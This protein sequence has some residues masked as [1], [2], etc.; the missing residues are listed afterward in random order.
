MAGQRQIWPGMFSYQEISKNG[1]D[2][3]QKLELSVHK[4][5]ETIHIRLFGGGLFVMSDIFHKLVWN[6][7]NTKNIINMIK[8]LT[9]AFA[10]MLLCLYASAQG[11]GGPHYPSPIV[12]PDNTVTFNLNAPQAK[13]VRIS[14]QFAPKADMQRLDNGVWTITLGPVTPD[15]Y[16]YCFEVD[17]IAVMDPQ[18]PEWFPNEKFKN[19]L[20]DVRGDKPLAHELRSVPH[21]KVDY[22]N[23][24]SETMGVYGNAIVYTPPTYDKNPD[25]KYPVFYLISGTTDTEEVYFKVGRMN[26]ILDNL[27]AEGKAKEMI[28]VLPYGN[29][30]KYF[31]AGTFD[32]TKGDVFSKDLLNDLMPYVEANYRTLNDRDSRA[33]GGFSR[34]G[35]QGLAFGLSNLD[36][37][38]YLCSYSSFTSKDIPGVYDKA[39]K[40]NKKINLFWLGVGTDDFLYGNAKEYAEFLDSKGI[41]NIQ[42]YTTGMFGHTWMNARY[43]LSE[44]FPLL[45]NKEASKAAMDQASKDKPKKVKKVEDKPEAPAAKPDQQRLTPEVMAR[46]F[47]P[48]VVS[49]DYNKDG[50]VTFRVLAP[51]AEKVEL[52]CQMFEGTRLMTKDDRGVWEVT[53]TPEVP[54][55]YP[56]SFIIDGTK[57]ADPENMNIFPNE[58]YKA[59][60]ADIKAAQPDPQDLQ[61]VPHGKVTYTYYTSNAVGFDRPVCIYTPA[62]YD[63]AGTEKY[64]VLYLIHG[65]TDTY[66]T[67]FKVGKVNNILDNLIAAGLAKKM[68]VVMPYANPYP[69]MMLRGMAKA[70]NALDTQLTT[71]EFTES[72][73]PFIEANYN[74]LTDADNRAIAGFSLGGRQ[75]LACGLG[76]PDMFHYV[77]AFAPAIFGPEIKANFENGTYADASKINDSLKLVWLSCGTSDF[78]YQS[79]LALEKEMVERNIDHKTMYPGGGHTWMNCRDY[80]IEVAKLLFK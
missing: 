6:Y 5:T 10:A 73:V 50:S 65:M 26:L 41:R 20:L 4:H 68:I 18:N 46:L 69:E 67:W 7:R 15:I 61:D 36:K 14:A 71:K 58:G 39:K 28:I 79:S 42:E 44:T 76:N 3:I 22:V 63:P 43:F 32:F 56:Y 27:I 37:F 11:F 8:R 47:P 59:S 75:T 57:I 16:P 23:Y 64:P 49:P 30:S 53:M 9:I 38:S 17:G 60:L 40:T 74:V 35:N 13:N 52:E 24:Y 51:D 19:S 33:I 62:G 77:C 45:F 34:G 54:D 25:K 80:L 66:E 1:S 2:S 29:P 48:G 55:I 31:P 78:L 70:Y 21:G 12:H 72:V